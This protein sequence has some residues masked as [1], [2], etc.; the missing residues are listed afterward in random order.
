MDMEQI[1][2]I[3]DFKTKY[4][5][6]KFENRRWNVISLNQ[7]QGISAKMTANRIR[8]HARTNP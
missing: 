2:L 1:Q 5:C 4:V 8:T 7:P 6:F 3:V